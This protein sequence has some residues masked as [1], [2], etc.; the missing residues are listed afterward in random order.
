MKHISLFLLLCLVFSLFSCAVH[1]TEKLPEE[2]PGFPSQTSSPL[3]SEEIID[4]CTFGWNFHCETYEEYL[5][6]F[7]QTMEYKENFFSF[8]DLMLLEGCEFYEFWANVDPKHS[9]PFSSTDQLEFYTYVVKYAND[10][11]TFSFYANQTLID[12]KKSLSSEEVCADRL[13]CTAEPTES[14]YLSA[15]GIEYHYYE[16]KL[17]QICWLENEVLVKVSYTNDRSL[18]KGLRAYYDPTGE[19]FLT[20]LLDPQ[21]AK[22]ATDWF[23][24]RTPYPWKNAATL[25]GKEE[26][27]A[28]LALW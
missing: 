9:L 4:G 8:E 23:G 1:E 26:T 19:A 5:Q 27:D 24:S 22:E 14:V 17:S 20:K 25:N 7:K 12:P 21:R 10:F 16:K 11:W 28:F 18:A 15:D 13:T 3:E 6:E 2:S